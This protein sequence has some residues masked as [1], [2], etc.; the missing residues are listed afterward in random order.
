MKFVS[1]GP[2]AALFCAAPSIAE[3]AEP[4]TDPILV[5]SQVEGSSSGSTA[6]FTPVIGKES[7]LAT[8][9][10]LRNLTATWSSTSTR[11]EP[12]A[13][14][15]LAETREARAI[16]CVAERVNVI[17][18]KNGVLTNVDSFGRDGDESTLAVRTAE[19]L[20]THVGDPTTKTKAAIKRAPV[21]E[22]VDDER[23]GSGAG[24]DRSVKRDPKSFVGVGVGALAHPGGGR[25][26][27]QGFLS[28]AFERRFAPD[29]AGNVA[30][31]WGAG[32]TIDGA[33]SSADTRIATGALGFRWALTSEKNRLVPWIGPSLG[34]F[35]L[36]VRGQKAPYARDTQ[37]DDVVLPFAA[38]NANITLR[39]AGPLRM[40]LEGTAGLLTGKI[41]IAEVDGVLGPFVLSAQARAEVG[42]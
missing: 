27:A 42:F 35:W 36:H 25:G 5:F 17:V 14:E 8:E 24:A 33:T 38:A 23:A 30:L 41:R 22:E 6:A 28:L 2:L 16:I 13:L 18:R 19:A 40:G 21:S 15:G 26:V 7:A 3:A 1:C 9:L 20:R 29:L 39:I 4:V 10:W 37:S 12:S 34:A 32:Q 31:G 11:C